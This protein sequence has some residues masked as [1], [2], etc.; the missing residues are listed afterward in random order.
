[1]TAKHFIPAVIALCLSGTVSSSAWAEQI[2][3]ITPEKMKAG[4]ARTGGIYLP[5]Q[6][7]PNGTWGCVSGN[8]TITVCGGI[9]PKHKRTCTQARVQGAD[10]RMSINRRLVRQR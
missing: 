9:T 4:C 6:P 7:G 5:K 2:P 1:M 8:G 10:N 3:V